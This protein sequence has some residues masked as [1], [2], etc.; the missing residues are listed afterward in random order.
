MYEP[1]NSRKR[2]RNANSR[3]K[4]H[5]QPTKA[6]KTCIMKH[7]DH[8]R[9]LAAQLFAVALIARS[10]LALQFDKGAV[11]MISRCRGLLTVSLVTAWAAGLPVQANAQVAVD[12]IGTLPVGDY[13]TFIAP[14]DPNGW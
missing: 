10:R 12:V 4:L 5:H 8:S 2:S 11:V 6:M 7:V 1:V 13:N 9:T 3:K 14:Y